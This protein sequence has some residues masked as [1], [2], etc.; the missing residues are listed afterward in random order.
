MGL[1]RSFARRFRLKDERTSTSTSQEAEFTRRRAR[2][3]QRLSKGSRGDGKLFREEITQAHEGCEFHFLHRGEKM[4]EAEI[5]LRRR[6]SRLR[7]RRPRIFSLVE[8]SFFALLRH[9]EPLPV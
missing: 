7:S 1:R 3:Q 5:Q 6:R 8:Q 2:W 4:A 9:S